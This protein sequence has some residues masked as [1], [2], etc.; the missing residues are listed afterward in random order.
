MPFLHFPNSGPFHTSPLTTLNHTCLSTQEVITSDQ[1]CPGRCQGLSSHLRASVWFQK[2]SRIRAL[3]GFISIGQLVARLHKDDQ[4]LC[5][6]LIFQGKGN[7]ASYKDVPK[8][9]SFTIDAHHAA[10][11]TLKIKQRQTSAHIFPHNKASHSRKQKFQ[12]PLQ[13]T[14]TAKNPVPRL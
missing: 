1:E 8:I 10:D 7:L 6:L 14:S 11:C 13:Q 9:A 4:S 2:H 3:L 5:L 12:K